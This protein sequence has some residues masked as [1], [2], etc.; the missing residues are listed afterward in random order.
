MS[1]TTTSTTSSLDLITTEDFYTTPCN[2]YKNMKNDYL[3]TREQIGTALEYK[4]PRKAI[5]NI[6]SK[7]KDR[8]DRFSV[9]HKLRAT[10][11]K[12]YDTILYTEKGV[13]EICRWSRQ[14]KADEFMDWTWNIIEAYRNKSLELHD[15]SHIQSAITKS[16]DNLADSIN[17]LNERINTIEHNKRDLNLPKKNQPQ[18]SNWSTWSAIMM[19]KYAELKKKYNCPSNAELYK[20]LYF[21]FTKLHPEYDLNNLKKEYCRKNNLNDCY[22]LDAIEH[23]DPAR[24]LFEEMVDNLIEENK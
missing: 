2:F 8:L 16:L 5:N 3:L 6:H 18:T 23:N 7:H 10:D 22:T 1:N 12:Y 4:D 11:G 15:L 14:K 17:K 19:P 13:M 20:E 24:N 9:I 21:R